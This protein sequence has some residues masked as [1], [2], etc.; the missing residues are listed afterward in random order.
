[1]PHLSWRASDGQGTAFVGGGCG[2]SGGGENP[3][4]RLMQLARGIPILG[5]WLTRRLGNR[6]RGHSWRMHC[7]FWPA[8]APAATA[9]TLE[10]S[11]LG[12]SRPVLSQDE[13]DTLDHWEP[14]RTV[15][16][17]G[18]IVIPL[19]PVSQRQEAHAR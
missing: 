3:N 18:E 1:M 15:P 8:I 14:A 6:P 19:S 2:G 9:L 16:S 4:V 5:R 13:P 11:S 17:M 7:S 12:L 10:V